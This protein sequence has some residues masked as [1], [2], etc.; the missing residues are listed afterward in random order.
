MIL[1]LLLGYTTA[2]H[3]LVLLMADG[4]KGMRLQYANNPWAWAIT[5]N[6]IHPRKNN[7]HNDANNETGSNTFN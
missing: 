7:Q 2:V 1:D 3:L 5:H 4:G 6:L